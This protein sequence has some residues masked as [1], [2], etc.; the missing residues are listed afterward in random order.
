MDVGALNPAAVESQRVPAY[1][2]PVGLAVA[3][4]DGVREGPE[5]G[6]R[7][8]GLVETARAGRFLAV[9]HGEHQARNAVG[10]IDFD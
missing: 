2:D 9:A 1:V 7:T 3:W 10:G 5:V 8:S 4:L 6:V